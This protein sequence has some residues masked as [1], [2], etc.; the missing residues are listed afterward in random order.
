MGYKVVFKITFYIDEVCLEKML[1]LSLMLISH[2]IFLVNKSLYIDF[3]SHSNFYNCSLS[4]FFVT[5]SEFLIL[6]FILNAI[7]WCSKCSYNTAGAYLVVLSVSGS[8]SIKFPIPLNT[9]LFADSPQFLMLVS[10]SKYLP[11]GEILSPSPFAHLNHT[12][13]L[14]LS[15]MFPS[16]GSSLSF[17]YPGLMPPHRGPTELC[18]PTF[19]L[20]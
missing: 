9:E 12:L 13:L 18:L 8:H 16:S 6:R 1:I 11:Q 20:F 19:C 3:L 15:Q 10:F 14:Q 5:F 17:L 4:L 2:L 7:V